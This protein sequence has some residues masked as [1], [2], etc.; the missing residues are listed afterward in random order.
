MNSLEKSLKLVIKLLS[1][2][3]VRF[4]YLCS[5][6]YQECSLF[7]IGDMCAVGCFIDSCKNCVN[8]DQNDEQYCLNSRTLTYNDV[9]RHGRVGGNQTTRTFG[10]YSAANTVHEDFIS[11]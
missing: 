4:L 7:Q 9:K 10:G 11:K 2:K 1:S 8:C 6:E 5:V 3:Y